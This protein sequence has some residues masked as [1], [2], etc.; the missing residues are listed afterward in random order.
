M[1]DFN[2]KKNLLFFFELVLAVTLCVFVFIL[3]RNWMLTGVCI[4]ITVGFL[5]IFVLYLRIFDSYLSD[6]LQKLSEM[7]ESI[8]QLREE[9]VFSIT[10]D[11]LLS[12][13]QMQLFK[14]TGI[15]KK[16]NKRMSEEKKEIKGLIS[17]ISHQLKTP[18]AN[19]QLY[20]SLI[21]Q[22]GITDE[23]KRGYEEVLFESIDKLS[24]LAESMIQ[25][26]RLESGVIQL[27]EEEQNINETLLQALK[28]VYRMA[29]V[30]DTHIVL[31][32][33][34]QELILHDRS[35]TA[36]AI[37]NLLDNAV[38]Y[39]N[40]GSKVMVFLKS[41][42]MFVCIEIRDYCTPIPESEHEKVFHRFFRGQNVSIEEG[43]GIGLYLTR[44]IVEMQGGY[45]KLKSYPDGNSF[46][47]YLPR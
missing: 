11:N 15:L 39:S 12:K 38:K 37:Y 40:R 16:Q 8:M 23:E 14:L 43:I 33:K 41:Y 47:I 3:S 45:I 10:E 7:I 30:K 34:Q 26:S 32:E 13:L 5:I 20:S 42:E 46:M 6:V 36:E 28:Q 24:F 22:T 17:D 9:E 2:M 44:K 35:W 4:G 29:K 25:M 19:M 1:K 27:K 21:K 31:H 18:L